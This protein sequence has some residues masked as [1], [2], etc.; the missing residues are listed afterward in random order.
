M[1][2]SR[3]P[4]YMRVFSFNIQNSETIHFANFNIAWHN[5]KSSKFSFFSFYSISISLSF[6]LSLWIFCVFW[7]FF[8]YFWPFFFLRLVKVRFWLYQISVFKT[9]VAALLV[10]KMQSD[11]VV[12][13]TSLPAPAKRPIRARCATKVHKSHQLLYRL[14]LHTPTPP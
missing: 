9:T 8:L 14:G 5:E 7:V 13:P 3:S 4:Y 11:V 12:N 2:F 6:F 10:V 1:Y